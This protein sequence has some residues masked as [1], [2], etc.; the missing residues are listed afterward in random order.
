[1]LTVLG[2]FNNL[3]SDLRDVPGALPS[4]THEDIAITVARATAKVQEEYER[5]VSSTAC[6][7][8]SDHHFKQALSQQ[9]A[10]SLRRLV[11]LSTWVDKELSECDSPEDSDEDSPTEA[12]LIGSLLDSPLPQQPDRH[13]GPSEEDDSRP[14]ESPERPPEIHSKLAFTKSSKCDS[15]VY[16]NVEPL[17][18][19]RILHK[20]Q[21]SL[22]SSSRS[23]IPLSKRVWDFLFTKDLLMGPDRREGLVQ[24]ARN[25]MSKVRDSV[26]GSMAH[27]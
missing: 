16:I 19:E 24:V 3:L 17:D 10:L 23:N 11:Q 22:I 9:H 25:V 18:G 4:A 12:S 26:A 6:R 2:N 5:F 7:A 20:H 15:K 27:F 14:K 13:A 21:S 8:L 1:M